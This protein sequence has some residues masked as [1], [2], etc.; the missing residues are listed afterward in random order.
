VFSER[1]ASP[2]W[3]LSAEGVAEITSVEVSRGASVEE[4]DEVKYRKESA[5]SYNAPE[6]ACSRWS[7]A[8]N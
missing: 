3:V 4:L 8:S 6:L 1:E 2:A 7:L 5:K